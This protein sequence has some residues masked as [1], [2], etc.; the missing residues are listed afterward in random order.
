MTHY[1]THNFGSNSK[2]QKDE[3]KDDT[4][5]YLGLLLKL[6]YLYELNQRMME[7]CDL[8]LQCE[9]WML[10]NSCETPHLHH[11]R[12]ISENCVRHHWL[13]KEAERRMTTGV[14]RL[15]GITH[16][17]KEIHE[18]FTSYFCRTIL[19]TLTEGLEEIY[20]FQNLH[21]KI[22]IS[23]IKIQEISQHPSLDGLTAMY[24]KCLEEEQILPLQKVVNNK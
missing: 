13:R 5:R 24:Y 6:G 14:K 21:W 10:L 12:C 1:S 20:L 3:E 7:D 8:S 4:I 23:W 22:E 18:Q 9:D 15:N 11:E 2:H 19:E 17:E 16:M